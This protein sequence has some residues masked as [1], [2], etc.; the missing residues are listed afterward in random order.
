MKTIIRISILLLL[1][2]ALP[3]LSAGEEYNRAKPQAKFNKRYEFKIH[4][5]LNNYVFEVTGL[6]SSPK[7]KMTIYIK[8]KAKPIQ[9][10]T[11]TE[12]NVGCDTVGI[13]DDEFTLTVEDINFDGYKDLKML[14]TRGGAGR[15]SFTY[16]LFD[17]ATGKINFRSNIELSQPR[18]DRAKKEIVEYEN[19]G[20][21]GVLHIIRYYKFLNDTFTL[22]REVDQTE[23]VYKGDETYYHKV[24]K[25]LRNGEMV[26]VV[27]KL[28][29]MDE[30]G[31]E[32]D[33]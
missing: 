8:G 33:Y 31:E 17:K 28:V 21:A 26:V 10:I 11:L 15:E 2:I 12:E 20:D 22:F 1:S 24:I 18:I 6:Q 3:S 4:S 7:K 23:H 27:D 25:E 30:I 29:S 19:W 16:W 9:A 32:P 13:S 14:C 5:S